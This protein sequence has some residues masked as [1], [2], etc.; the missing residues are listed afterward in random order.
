MNRRAAL[1]LVG[2]SPFLGRGAVRASPRSPGGLDLEAV[3]AAPWRLV[4][5]V[6]GGSL[7]G[8]QVTRAWQGPV[9]RSAVVN[10]GPS[11]ARIREVVV[12]DVP[13]ALP[14]ET[15][16]YGEGFQML[17][18]TGARS[19][20]PPTLATTRTPATTGCRSPPMRSSPM[21]S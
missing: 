8:V 4:P 13:H 2:A 21:G 18:Q 15:G 7:A 20:G 19:A 14:G 5:A 16:L 17:S 10:T 11:P 6:E 12:L 3:K 1:R 9:C